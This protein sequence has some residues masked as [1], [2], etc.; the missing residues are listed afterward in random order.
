MATLMLIRKLPYPDNNV[1]GSELIDYTLTRH[2]AEIQTIACGAS[3][4]CFLALV[5]ALAYI[6]NQR[7]GGMTLPVCFMIGAMACWTSLALATAAL[8]MAI[9]LLAGGYR[10]FGSTTADQHLVTML[11]DTQNMLWTMSLLPLG[12]TLIALHYANRVDQILP[13]MLTGPGVVI[14]VG[15]AWMSL[16]SVFIHSGTWSPGSFG[17]MLVGTAPALVWL[18]AAGLALLRIP[19]VLCTGKVSN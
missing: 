4:C 1:S 2:S 11:W 6:Y 12:I 10:G 14:T 19:A 3:V 17:S 7:A 18:A 5:T 8:Y 16:S 13:R 15:L 9:G